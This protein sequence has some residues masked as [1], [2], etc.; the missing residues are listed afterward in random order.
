[1][2]FIE[3]RIYPDG[4]DSGTLELYKNL[5]VADVADGLDMMGLPVR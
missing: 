1:M 4:D 2:S 3:T 5:R